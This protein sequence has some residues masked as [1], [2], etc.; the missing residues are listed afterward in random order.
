MGITHI[1]NLSEEY[2]NNNLESAKEKKDL[3]G[4]L[5]RCDKCG[6][7]ILERLKD[8]TDISHK[9]SCMKKEIVQAKLNKFKK[10]SILDKR[11]KESKFCNAE[12]KYPE[13][14]KIYK[15]IKNY[16]KNFDKV[17]QINDG[18]MFIG[19]CGT[20]KTF[21]ANCICNYLIEKNY[22]VLAFNLSGYLRA[23]RDDFSLEN[24]FLEAIR[25]ADLVFIDDLGSEKLTEEWGKEKIFSLIDTRYGAQKP[26][27]ITTNLDATELKEFLL[28]KGSNKLVDRLNE[29]TKTRVFNWKSRRINA[30]KSFWEER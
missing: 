16:I 8:G 22:T 12:P 21:L 20:G 13:E 23:L 11:S 19:K 28:Y 24:K 18:L 25:E 26:I 30:S 27:I 1:G 10:L 15:E 17:L 9:C 2:K 3:V 7:P 29:M 14:I 5:T 6:E 4:I